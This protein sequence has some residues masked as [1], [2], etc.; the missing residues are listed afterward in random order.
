M[1]YAPHKPKK[2]K[3]N[4]GISTTASKVFQAVVFEENQT[5]L[6]KYTFRNKGCAHWKKYVL[7]KNPTSVESWKENNRPQEIH[8]QHPCWQ[9][10]VDI[11]KNRFQSVVI[12]TNYMLRCRPYLKHPPYKLVQTPGLETWSKRRI[13]ASRYVGRIILTA[14]S[15]IW[16]ITAFERVT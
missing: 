1:F 9:S 12:V 11:W 16:K 4:D 8:F 3:L 10:K 15:F 7:Y 6:Q 2:C 13:T 5:L 14:L